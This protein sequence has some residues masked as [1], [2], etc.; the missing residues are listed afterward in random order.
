MIIINIY[1]MINLFKTLIRVLFDLMD[2]RMM[3]NCKKT[4]NM[5]ELLKIEKMVVITI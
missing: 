3:N 2:E 1:L 4:D 5:V